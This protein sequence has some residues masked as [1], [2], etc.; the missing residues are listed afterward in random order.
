M[1]HPFSGRLNGASDVSAHAEWRVSVASSEITR[2]IHQ[3]LRRELGA[4]RRSVGAY[5]NEKSLW[6]ERPGLPNTGGNLA[7]HLAGNLQH[8]FGA[9]LGKTGYVRDRDL[10]FSRRGVPRSELL[11]QIDAAALAIDAG[12]Q[13]V[14]SERLAASYPEQVGGRTI[15]TQDFLVHL[16]SH[17]AYHLGQIDYHRRV[18]TG[19]SRSIG[20]IAVQELATPSA[21]EVG[22]AR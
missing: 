3:L 18:V 10:E 11:A 8:Y 7:L 15:S 12:M 2:T 13:A 22:P 4:V 16:L 21:S 19:D 17:L 9:V 6:V 1:P 20:A 5:P 14:N